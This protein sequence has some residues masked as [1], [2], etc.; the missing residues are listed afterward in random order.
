[1]LVAAA[2]MPRAA[3][4]SQ[5]LLDT[6]SGNLTASGDSLNTNLAPFALVRVGAS[7]VQIGGIGIYGQLFPNATAARANVRWS[8]FSA[9]GTSVYDS[10]PMLTNGSSTSTWFDSPGFQSPLTLNANSD[11]YY[12]LI[13]DASFLTR[14]YYDPEHPAG[15][16]TG[17]GISSP[18]GNQPG[19][20]GVVNGF[21]NPTLYSTSRVVQVGGRI[22]APVLSPTGTLSPVPIPLAAWLFGS[23][24]LVLAASA[25][26]GRGGALAVGR[27]YTV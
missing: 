27:A 10:G 6:V 26:R 4:A 11:Y 20:N 16:I 2:A 8:I 23:G 7:D 14:Y 15:T 5:T 21:G 1:M 19:S 17:N 12:G 18:G 3:D 9:N 13:T 25:R 22:L 24:L